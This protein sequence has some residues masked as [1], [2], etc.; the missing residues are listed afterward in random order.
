[1]GR[2]KCL[3]HGLIVDFASYKRLKKLE[4]IEE[5]RNKND[6]NLVG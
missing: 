5:V 1:M 2:A 3:K 4:C 6:G